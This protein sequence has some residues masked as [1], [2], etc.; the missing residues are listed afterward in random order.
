MRGPRRRADTVKLFALAAAAFTAWLF[1]QLADD[2]TDGET[3]DFD[4]AVLL[5]FREDGERD[6]PLGPAWVEELARDVTGLGSTVVLTFA[7]LAT[8]GFFLLRRKWHLAIY[9]AAAVASG[10]AA[11]LLLKSGFDRPRP[12]LVAHGQHVYTASF[13][14]G[15]S[16]LSAV[17]FLTLG[18]LLAG[19]LKGRAMQLYVLGLSA[20][21]ALA[22]GV[23]R[24]VPRRA[25]ADGRA[26]RLGSGNGMGAIVLGRVAAAAQS[27]P[28]RMTG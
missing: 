27:W 26:R 10:S 7:T 21:L 2:V 20:L 13:P 23:S 16:M 1:L 22:V 5:A 9:V 24:G 12:D 8:A 14:S 18:A 28:D 19:A 11:S 25:L 6:D 15:H 3:R 4:E 17:A